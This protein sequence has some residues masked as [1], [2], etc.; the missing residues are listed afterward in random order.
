MTTLTDELRLLANGPLGSEV[1]RAAAEEIDRLATLAQGRQ[2]LGMAAIFMAEIIDTDQMAAA[3]ADYLASFAEAFIADAFDAGETT[4]EAL[5][6]RARR[7]RE[8]S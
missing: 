4:L 5:T 2:E 6:A 3:R 8:G 7:I 1:L